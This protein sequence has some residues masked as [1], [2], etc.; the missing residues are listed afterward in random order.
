LLSRNVVAKKYGVVY[1]LN[2]ELAAVYNKK[3]DLNKH[4][5]DDSNE[6]PIAATYIIDTNGKIVYAY[7]DYDYRNRAEPKDL[8]EFLKNF[9]KK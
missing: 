9:N 7:V 1:K 6:L 8:T 5:G 2:D 4:N 3:F